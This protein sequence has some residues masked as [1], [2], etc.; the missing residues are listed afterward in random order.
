MRSAFNYAW[1]VAALWIFGLLV[2][3]WSSLQS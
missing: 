3:V 2:L 1:N